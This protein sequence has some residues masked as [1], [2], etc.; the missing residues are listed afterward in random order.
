MLTLTP[1]AS[2]AAFLLFTA[3]YKNVPKPFTPFLLPTGISVGFGKIV[4]VVLSRWVGNGKFS[5]CWRKITF[6]RKW[7]LVN[8]THA[9]LCEH[10]FHR[11]RDKEATSGSISW[12]NFVRES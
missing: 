9:R 10:V 12:N 11:V 2:E 1:K 5:C 8:A 4:V 7:K 3:T 6:A